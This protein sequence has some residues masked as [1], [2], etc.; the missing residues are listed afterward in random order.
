MLPLK[1][2]MPFETVGIRRFIDLDGD[3]R[4]GR[5][6]VGP[7]ISSTAELER[8]RM[9]HSAGPAD[10]MPAAACVARGA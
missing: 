2:S 9:G 7:L 5:R 3:K 6:F 8:A 1:L 4:G 10:A